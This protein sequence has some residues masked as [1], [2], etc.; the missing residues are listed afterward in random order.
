MTPQKH[1]KKNTASAS[2]KGDSVTLSTLTCPLRGTR[3]LRR[4]ASRA[5]KTA[6]VDPKRFRV[7]FVRNT[8]QGPQFA[9]RSNSKPPKDDDD[10][11]TADP[12]PATLHVVVNLD[13]HCFDPVTEPSDNNNC[14]SNAFDATFNKASTHSLG[15][16][17]R[18]LGDE[19]DWIQL[20]PTLVGRDV[21]VVDEETGTAYV[22]DARKV[23]WEKMGVNATVAR[24]TRALKALLNQT[25]RLV[26][27][28]F[29]ATNKP[30]GSANAT[31]GG[32]LERAAWALALEDA[33]QRIGRQAAVRVCY[34]GA[35]FDLL[36]TAFIHAFDAAPYLWPL[37]RARVVDLRT[38]HV[39]PRTREDA[40][41]RE[42]PYDYRPAAAYPRA[43]RFMADLFNPGGG[44]AGA[45]LV[46]FMRR[47]LGY[48]LT[49]LVTERK[50]STFE[51]VG[52]NGKS[53][54][55]DV[56]MQVLGPF[57]VI[58]PGELAVRAR[59]ANE[60]APAPHILML[61]G[62]RLAVLDE[63]G[64]GARP[65]DWALKR[66]A[67]GNALSAR[68][69]RSNDYLT[70]KPRLKV[71]LC[72]N[73][74]LQWDV[75][76][77]AMRDRMQ[78]IHFPARFERTSLSNSVAGKARDPHILDTFD[79]AEFFAY[80][81]SGAVELFAPPYNGHNPPPACVCQATNRAVA[82]LDTMGMFVEECCELDPAAQTSKAD[83]MRAYVQFTTAN[84][85]P[86]LP[87]A[88]RLDALRAVCPAITEKRTKK[89]RGLTGIRLV[90]LSAMDTGA[91]DDVEEEED[92]V[93]SSKSTVRD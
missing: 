67:S 49:A 28:L 11:G 64:D 42:G 27:A 52:L 38:G 41:T 5:V 36:D 9:V 74:G 59:H 55:V 47:K 40:F 54:L 70:L 84:R 71:V 46:G 13:T 8:V 86:T 35:S 24:V 57:F 33:R 19:E 82:N 89:M 50:I 61:R 25:Q 6:I 29:D 21:K 58:L 83:V 81:V 22:F 91:G 15:L 60:G 56:L 66:L 14:S 92:G 85:L 3:L 87:P 20:L 48:F 34:R 93:S 2:D 31:D 80:M 44:E 75:T 32:D 69:M 1:P 37:P 26:D 53:T 65:N 4:L 78:A 7:S 72:T 63:I 73:K 45:E 68:G 10:D 16:A 76:D 39:R 90:S 18:L 62:A 30:S 43:E 12:P 17:L 88:R 79:F 77:Q 51:G 23:L